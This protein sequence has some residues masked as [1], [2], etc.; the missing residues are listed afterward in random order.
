MQCIIE[1]I[2][3]YVIKDDCCEF[4]LNKYLFLCFCFTKK[5]RKKLNNRMKKRTN[6]G[7]IYGA[8]QRGEID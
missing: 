8:A 2:C 5:R 4:K 1:E 3:N 7:G 6:H